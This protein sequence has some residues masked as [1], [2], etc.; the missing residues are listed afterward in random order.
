[1][2]Q[3][4]LEEALQEDVKLADAYEEFYWRVRRRMTH[5]FVTA[6]FLR[7][8]LN[9][10]EPGWDTVYGEA[11]VK[12]LWGERCTTKDSECP[13][14]IAWDIYDRQSAAGIEEC[15]PTIGEVTTEGR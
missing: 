15:E 13:T 2:T 11:L 14:C 8:L 1:M 6:Q 10:I 12:R 5:G 7:D 3:E 9:R 4:D